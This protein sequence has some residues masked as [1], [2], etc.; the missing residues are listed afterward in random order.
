M[1]QGGNRGRSAVGR[2]IVPFHRIGPHQVEAAISAVH[3]QLKLAADMDWATINPSPAVGLNHAVAVA[4]SEGLERGL[5]LINQIG[6]AG[7][8][9][10]YYLFHTARA[11]LLRRFGKRFDAEAA[12]REAL[13]LTSNPVEQ[14]YLRQ[15][16]AALT[17]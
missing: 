7:E 2:A 17:S 12:Y 8:L 6:A 11:D 14:A 4:M 3:A 10:H 13:T 9:S 16:L 15:R 5:E 1:G